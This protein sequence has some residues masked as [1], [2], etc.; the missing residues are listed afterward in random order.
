[1]K[2]LVVIADKE[3][4]KNIA[5]QRA[6]ILQQ[7]TGSKITLLGFCYTDFDSPELLKVAN[8]NTDQV[9]KSLYEKRLEELQKLSKNLKIKPSS[10]NIVPIWSKDIANYVNTYCSKNPV[11]LVIKS[12]H[13]SET[14]LY[15]S[16]DWQLLRECPAP[17]MITA[18]KNWKKKPRIVAAIDFATK[19]KSKIKLNHD[20]M[21]HALELAKYLEQDV[22]IAYSLTVPRALADLDIID[23]RKYARDKRKTLQPTIDAFCKEYGIDSDHLH[24]KLGSAEVAIPSIANKL[25]A[26]V[27]ITGTVGRRGI[28][29]KLLGNT[30]EGILSRL[31]TDIIAIKP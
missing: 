20:I 1:M 22:H 23:P 19:V 24:I 2:N 15:T 31:R 28:K 9:E 4:G 17:V 13:R 21:E 30:A 5:L 3:G 14:F 6:S 8:I 26:D 25:K 29:G 10:I 12:A 27:V 7:Q 11:D 18:T 16:T